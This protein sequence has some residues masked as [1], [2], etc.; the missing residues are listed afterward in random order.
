M[1]K[2]PH[3]LNTTKRVRD[4]KNT[5]GSL[6]A[7]YSLIVDV[8]VPYQRKSRGDVKQ[9]LTCVQ[10]LRGLWSYIFARENCDIQYRASQHFVDA[11]Q[12]YF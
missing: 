12:V 4:I 7:H 1:F 9:D 5:C 2:I 11:V 10:T 6:I 8:V 3:H